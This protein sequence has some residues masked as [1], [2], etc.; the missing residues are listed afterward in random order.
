MK[1]GTKIFLSIFIIALIVA[2]VV[3]AV[4]L[5]G[6][7][8]DDEKEA[9]TKKVK[10]G[11]VYLKILKDEDNF[12]DLK[13]IELRICDFNNDDYPELVVS[14][15]KKINDKVLTKI[16]SINKEEEVDTVQFELEDNYDLE[17]LYHNE[18]ETYGWY[19]IVD[20]DELYEVQIEDKNYEIEQSDYELDEFAHVSAPEVVYFD[21]EDSK[22][23]DTIKELEEVYTTYVKE[24]YEDIE[25]DEK[26]NDRQD[27]EKV[28]DKDDDKDD[29]KVSDNSHDDDYGL[30]VGD[31]DG[32]YVGYFYSFVQSD[33]SKEYPLAS[34]FGQ[35]DGDK[36]YLFFADIDL[37]DIPEMYV[38]C[39]GKDGM[40]SR[41][42][43][44]TYS[45]DT[46]VTNSNGP[47]MSDTIKLVKNEDGEYCYF[48][49]ELDY[50]GKDYAEGT[51]TSFKIVNTK[52]RKQFGVSYRPQSIDSVPAELEEMDVPEIDDYNADY[53][54]TDITMEEFK[55]YAKDY[56]DEYQYSGEKDLIEKYR[57]E[58]DEFSDEEIV[59][60]IPEAYSN[61]EE[62]IEKIK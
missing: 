49:S 51:D 50:P 14:G 27:E 15:V 43:F 12:E 34:T 30:G 13:D 22:P 54:W 7:S 53:V 18:E 47:Y 8:E 35:K 9:S 26:K 6:K 5:F 24:I 36:Y 62:M 21:P 31:E 25:K 38:I 1:K 20:D 58:L 11:D 59:D 44:L 10:W 55:K 61:Y 19:A 46:G 57:I 4:I 42:I 52:T 2:V 16:F 28:D 37:N 33:E 3:L 41:S 32:S 48:E 29:D 56:K 40:N 60:K 17:F 39:E 45:E 23:K